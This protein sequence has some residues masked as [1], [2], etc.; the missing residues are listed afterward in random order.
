[1][2]LLAATMLLGGCQTMKQDAR[3][4]TKAF[5]IDKNSRHIP[6]PE[7][8][9]ET[10]VLGDPAMDLRQWTPSSAHYVND[11]VVAGPT[12]SPLKVSQLHCGG[13]AIVEPVLFF[14]NSLYTPFG[15]FV[16]APW[17]DIA[18]KSL[19]TNPSYTVMPPLPNGPSKAPPYY[20]Y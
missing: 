13:N 16:T 20:Y 18:Y 2:M 4:D 9:N 7:K 12:Y 11:V 10:V 6:P 5:Y 14:A 1:M 15:C 17:A 3:D 19:T 8:L